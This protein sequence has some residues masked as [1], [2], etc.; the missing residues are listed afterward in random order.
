M[1]IKNSGYVFIFLLLFILSEPVFFKATPQDNSEIIIFPAYAWTDM[2]GIITSIHAWVFD[3]EKDSLSRKVIIDL[4]D[5]VIKDASDDEIS[6]LNKRMQYFLADNK[7]GINLKINIS[8]NYYPLTETS[9]NGHSVTILKLHDKAY[10]KL[11]FSINY[12]KTEP[13]SDS[14]RIIG[15]K[16]LSVISDFD[17]TIKIS[18]VANKKEMLKNVFLRRFRPVKGMSELY[19]M[20]RDKGAVF[21]YISGSPWQLYPSIKTF[22]QDEKFPE[23]SVELKTFRLK[24]KSA[25]SVITADQFSYKLNAICTVINRFPQRDFILIGDSGEKDPEVYCEIARCYKNRIRYI[26]IRNVGLIGDKFPKRKKII[27][28]AGKVPVIIFQNPEELNSLINKL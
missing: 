10:N 12:H 16:G 28:K 25:V 22:L 15:K 14:I 24:D 23:G 20:I 27:T 17:D 1:T 7:K 9:P 19:R 18:D 5:H 13:V 26:F 3:P 6:M 4:L 2:D 21:H 8:G 11:N